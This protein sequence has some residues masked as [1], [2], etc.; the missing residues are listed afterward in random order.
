[1][2]KS[3]GL[4]GVSAGETAICTVG[5]E[6][7][8]LRYYGYSIRDMTAGTRFEGCLAGSGPEVHVRFDGT[9]GNL[10]LG[11]TILDQQRLRDVDAAA[12]EGCRLGCVLPVARRHRV[13][14]RAMYERRDGRR[15]QQREKEH[16]QQHHAASI[17]SGAHGKHSGLSIKRW[18]MLYAARH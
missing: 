11:E 13:D 14:R 17:S 9:A 5:A 10:A 7:K 18:S 6:G 15:Q 12:R 4:E 1:M 16:H 3:A 8:D 2:A